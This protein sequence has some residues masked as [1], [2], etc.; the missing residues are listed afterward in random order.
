MITMK[1]ILILA[2]ALLVA[3]APLG[4]RSESASKSMKKEVKATA[5]QIEAD[6]FRML[7]LGDL[8][9]RLQSYFEK[10]GEGCTQIVGT[11]E[12]CISTNLAKVTAINNAANEYA[13]LCGGLVKGRIVSDAS[14]IS[15][16]QLD[17]IVAAYERLVYKRMG[18]ELIQWITLVREDN[19][20]YDVRSYCLIDIDAA[21]KARMHAMQTALEEASL[22][23][24]YGSM[25]S[26]WI[27]EGFDNL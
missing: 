3:A 23:E 24:E 8:R 14:N 13:T 2:A 7:E 27:S 4:A 19:G 26:E 20:G 5:R 17:D 9:S 10:V 6:G 25:V 16:A 18:G 22:A 21:H 12:G 1:K 11:A 15:G